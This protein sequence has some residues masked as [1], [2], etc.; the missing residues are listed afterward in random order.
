MAKLIKIQNL[1]EKYENCTACILGNQRQERGTK[2]VFG[3]G[4]LDA[5][6]MVVGESPGPQEEEHNMPLYPHAP[7]GEIFA[8]FLNYINVKREDIYITN[9]MIC[10]PLTAKK[11]VML[12]PDKAKTFGSVSSKIGSLYACNQRLLET[13]DIINPNVIVLLGAVAYSALFGSQPKTV[14]S[15][16]GKHAWNG[17]N[18]YLTYHP[19]FY[20]RK[21][22]FAN[23]PEEKNELV[24][25]T[26]I[27]KSHWSEIKTLSEIEKTPKNQN[28]LKETLKISKVLKEQYT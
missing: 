4:N 24:E 27:L 15:S 5:K 8:K 2:I 1:K 12:A 20:A 23:S 18:C 10:A 16:L 25:L 13:I 7:S 22:S 26:N 19:S 21:K 28:S 17:Y 9:S 3:E 14:T 6:I 11:A